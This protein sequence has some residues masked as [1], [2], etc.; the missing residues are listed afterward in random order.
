MYNKR[1]LLGL[2]AMASAFEGSNGKKNWDTRAVRES[3]PKPKKSIAETNKKLGL[4]EFSYGE[5]KVWALNK[6]NADKKAKKLGWI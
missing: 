2:M 4:Q 1:T 3:N 5:N 6:T